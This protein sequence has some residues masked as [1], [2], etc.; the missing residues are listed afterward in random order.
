[1]H[2]GRAAT[3][4]RADESADRIEFKKATV[5]LS[6]GR[7]QMRRITVEQLMEHVSAMSQQFAAHQSQLMISGLSKAVD[8][9]GNA[10][11][12]KEIGPKE[13]F[14]EM[15][16]RIQMEF[17]PQTLEP[18]SLVFVLHPD[19]VERFKAQAEEW[20]K[21]PEFVAERARIRQT[22]IEEWRAREDRRKLVD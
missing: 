17:D 12:A 21:D 5:E 6:I 1:V 2:E 9:V 14:L 20:E 19:D 16:R 8:E 11:S 15:E 3:L 4:T 10:V 7:D 18:K 13:A 22:K